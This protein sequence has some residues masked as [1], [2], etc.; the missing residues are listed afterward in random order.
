MCAC[1]PSANRHTAVLCKQAGTI[2]CG[3][4]RTNFFSKSGES[5]NST[6]HISRRGG[7]RPRPHHRISGGEG[8]EAAQSERVRR[9]R[10]YEILRNFAEEAVPIAGHS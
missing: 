4:K 1:W 5:G 8:T 7:V 6:G 3:E 10:I 2:P 9:L